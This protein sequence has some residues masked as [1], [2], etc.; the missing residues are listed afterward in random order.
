MNLALDMLGN[1][2]RVGDTLVDDRGKTFIAEETEPSYLRE[3]VVRVRGGS[4]VRLT[5]VF[6][7]DGS[8]GAAQAELRALYREL[9]ARFVQPARRAELL[10]RKAEITGPPK[11]GRRRE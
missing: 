11:R 8:P 5:H 6:R 10:R 2:V 3:K 9:R 4:T 1:E 7:Y